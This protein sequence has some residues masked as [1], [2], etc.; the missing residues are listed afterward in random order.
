MSGLEFSE[1][2]RQAL[3]AARRE[4]ARRGA[5]C[6]GP[7]HLLLGTLAEPSG[8]ATA[9]LESLGVDRAVLWQRLSEHLPAGHEEASDGAADVPFSQAAQRVLE[10]AMATA[11]EL[12]HVYVGGEHLLLAVLLER[13][14]QVLA[15]AADRPSLGADLLR[16]TGVTP[17]ALRRAVARTVAE[18]DLDAVL[19]P[20]E[21]PLTQLRTWWRRARTQ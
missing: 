16:D 7:E 10:A 8:L 17:A 5:S 19:L 9:A 12:Q 21:S 14:Q 18:A 3:V 13:E 20:G 1:P 6:V 15:V 4:A 2:G 11:R